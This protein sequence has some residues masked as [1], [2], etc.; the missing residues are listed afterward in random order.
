MPSEMSAGYKPLLFTTTVRNPER[1]K[2][3]MFVLSKFEG[4]VLTDGICEQICAEAIRVGLYRPMKQ[5]MSVKAKWRGSEGG[6]FAARVLS[7]IEVTW[8]LRNNPQK[9]KE[10]GFGYGWPSRFQTQFMI[11]RQLG[12]AYYEVGERIAISALGK[13][14]AG[15][16]T[17]FEDGDS[18]VVE[19]ADGGDEQEIFM[20]AMVKYHR[21]NPYLKVLN[22]N[23]PIVLLLKVIRLINADARFHN[24]GITRREILLLLFWKD[25]DA[26]AAY[27]M[28]VDLRLKHGYAP[29]K[30]VLLDEYC[31]KKILHAPPKVFDDDSLTKDYIDGYIRYM[32]LTGLVALRGAGTHLDVNHLMDARIDYILA[33]YS[34]YT[35]FTNRREYFDYVASIDSGLLA[36]KEK[37]VSGDMRYEYL[38]KWKDVY[39]WPQLKNELAILSKKKSSTDAVLKFLDGPKRLEFLAALAVL[40]RRPM[41]KVC[42]N[43]HC[44]D[45][46]LPTST[47]A[48]NQGDIE[49]YCDGGNVLLEVTLHEGTS[50]TKNEGW[51]VGRHLTDFATKHEPASCVFVAPTI[52]EDTVSQF[53]WS[54]NK[55]GH[56][57]VAMTIDELIGV[58]DVEGDRLSAGNLTQN[59]EA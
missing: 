10:S 31:F 44:D 14:L 47:A 52:F 15:Q 7:D 46:G 41:Y 1:I 30:E 34:S 23:C 33:N 16:V 37:S 49:C 24:C 42:P 26:E 20:H 12:F 6:D 38:S 27:R 39:N 9:H 5:L 43:Y 56:I 36:L 45:E 59:M 51:P 28:I 13:R 29:S 54:R 50:Q 19:E 21:D 22:R 32:R 55:N 18:L 4:Q 25:N 8:M 35:T 17:V 40:T 53:E 3:Y 48:G 11:T 58:L 57:T 2:K